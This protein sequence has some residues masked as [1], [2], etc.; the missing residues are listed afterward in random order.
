MAVLPLV[1]APDPR[2]KKVSEPVALNDI[3]DQLRKFLDDL[4]ET[5][6]A[7][8]GLGLA[9]VQV[10][11]HKRILVMDIAQGSI[12][13]DGTHAPDAEPDPLFLINPEI[14]WK[15]DE[16]FVFEEGC[17]SFPAQF[18]SVERPKRVRVRFYDYFGEEREMAFEGL[19]AVCVQHEIDHLNGIT[20]VEHVS[21]MKRD[22]IMRKLEK[23]KKKQ[24]E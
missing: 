7:S 15:S 19:A 20:F 8:N 13:Y 6:Y 24:A 1:I 2:L 17:L 23:A 10:A 21:K 5:M 22:Y 16:M 4:L 12:R 11:V 14:V 9:A 18:A 3:N